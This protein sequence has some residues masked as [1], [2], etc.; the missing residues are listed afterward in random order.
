MTTKTFVSVFRST[1]KADTYMYVRR[2]Q[3][4]G[5][6]PEDLRAIFGKPALAMELIMTPEKK[7][8]RTTGRAVLDAIADK[9]FF[10]QMPEEQSGSV[11]AFKERLRNS[12][13]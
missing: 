5:D 9:G 11:V 6:L 13:E 7:L 3:V 10:M 1:K 8:A 12:A 2:G 4:W